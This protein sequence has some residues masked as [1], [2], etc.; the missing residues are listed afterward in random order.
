[1]TLLHKKL[2]QSLTVSPRNP[3]SWKLLK[4]GSVK[5]IIR[6]VPMFMHEFWYVQIK[7]WDN[8]HI[9]KNVYWKYSPRVVI[10]KPR[11]EVER[12]R[13]DHKR[14]IFPIYTIQN[15]YID[16]INNFMPLIIVKRYENWKKKL[17]RDCV[18]FH[19]I[20]PIYT[21]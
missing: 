5:C 2:S 3:F 20:N 15:V 1:M 4:I 21:I 14:W 9:L 11:D 12:F 6:N 19:N 17:W 13:Y 10:S 18:Y 16:I 8:I 7:D